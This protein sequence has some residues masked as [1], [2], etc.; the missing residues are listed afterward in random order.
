MRHCERGEAIQEP[1][2]KC[3]DFEHGNQKPHPAFDSWIA[4]LRWQ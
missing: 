4:S 3:Y 1:H 2:E